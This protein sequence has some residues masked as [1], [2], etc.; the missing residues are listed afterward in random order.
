MSL[1]VFDLFSRLFS[2][3]LAIGWTANRPS[4]M[5]H[6]EGSIE[7]HTSFVVGRELS[8]IGARRSAMRQPDWIRSIC[9]SDPAN[10]N[11]D[12]RLIFDQERALERAIKQ[13]FL[14]L[15]LW[16]SEIF[17]LQIRDQNLRKLSNSSLACQAVSGIF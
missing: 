11:Q 2:T 4:L 9:G 8:S 15:T 17:E 16:L 7:G 13:Q 3:S 6:C 12:N 10:L 5:A 14:K 1:I